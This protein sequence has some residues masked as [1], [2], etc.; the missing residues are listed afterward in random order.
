MLDWFQDFD[1][2]DSSKDL[3]LNFLRIVYHQNK[4]LTVVFYFTRKDLC[5][6]DMGID[7]RSEMVWSRIRSP[8][9]CPFG[10]REANDPSKG[11][12]IF[13]INGVQWPDQSLVNDKP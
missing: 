5:H 7:H 9:W 11:S 6:G 2:I 10:I 8:D 13:K 1:I 3:A 12:W 4:R